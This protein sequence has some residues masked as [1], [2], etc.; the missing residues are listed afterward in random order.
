[1]RTLPLDDV[2]SHL[3]SDVVVG[4]FLSGGVDLRGV[5]TPMS[6]VAKEPVNTLTTS[7]SRWPQDEAPVATRVAQHFGTHLNEL[8]AKPASTEVVPI[9]AA[10]LDE[11]FA[12][13]SALPTLLAS[14]MAGEQAEVVLSGDSGDELF[15]GYAPCRGL[16]PSRLA[17][18]T[19]PGGRSA[20]AKCTV[21]GERPDGTQVASQ[22]FRNVS[23]LHDRVEKPVAGGTETVGLEEFVQTVRLAA[24]A[25]FDVSFGL[26]DDIK[27]SPSGKY[28]YTVSKVLE[29]DQAPGAST[30]LPIADS[31]GAP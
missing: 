20:I 8:V 31:A 23:R 16:R 26:V 29:G 28:R 15:L 19:P 27:P 6:K 5:V 12:D 4:A 11:P 30:S 18:S 3:L 25:D 21:R 17:G 14:W 7:F 2:R 10:R 9:S 22:Y 13:S 24:G 1:M